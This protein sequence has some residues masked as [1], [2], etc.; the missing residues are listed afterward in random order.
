MRAIERLTGKPVTGMDK[1]ATRALVHDGVLDRIYQWGDLPIVRVYTKV[2][3]DD[4]ASW[5][6]GGELIE[7]LLPR[8]T[9]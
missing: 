1:L 2:V 7:I 9:S 8:P 3:L 6:P 4:R 5:H